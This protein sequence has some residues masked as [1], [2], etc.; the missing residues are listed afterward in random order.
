MYLPEP[1]VGPDPQCLR[2]NCQRA[3]HPIQ[4]KAHQPTPGGGELGEYRVTHM[5]SLHVQYN[6]WVT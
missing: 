4:Q 2:E 3:N 5:A 1:G 6:V